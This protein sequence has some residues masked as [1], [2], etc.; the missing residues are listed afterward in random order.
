MIFRLKMMVREKTVLLSSE[1]RVCLGEDE[2][3]SE[4]RKVRSL[5]GVVFCLI[6][7]VGFLFF[8][9]AGGK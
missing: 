1:T 9:V 6:A 4:E 2:L 8:F 5:G 7:V 3:L